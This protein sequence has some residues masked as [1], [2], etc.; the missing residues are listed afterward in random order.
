LE[1]KAVEE[2][3]LRFEASPR[4]ARFFY[5]FEGEIEVFPAGEKVLLI[6]L[7]L[8]VSQQHENAIHVSARLKNRCSFDVTIVDLCPGSAKM[9]S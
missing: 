2:I 5:P 3:T 8:A 7:A 9:P 1:V 4:G 6:P